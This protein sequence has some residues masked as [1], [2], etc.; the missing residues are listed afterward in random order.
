MIAAILGGA[1]GVWQEIGALQHMVRPDII[2]A[3]N[4]AGAHYI[5]HIDH[6]VTLHPEKMA[7]WWDQRLRAGLPPPG[8]VWFHRAASREFVL[9]H[10]HTPEWGGSSGLFAVKVAMEIG[11]EKII[12][13]G[14]PMEGTP[15]FHVPAPL[16]GVGRY[17]RAWE[18]RVGQLAEN[19]RSMSGWT[20]QLLGQ[21][22]EVWLRDT[23]KNADGAEGSN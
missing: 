22:D 12:L 8:Q 14:I 3:T 4:D 15:H 1:E 11:C 7:A 5:G 17:R 23:R 20:A 13:C 2:I 18:E 6:W 19:V 10:L 9:P 16:K 21:P